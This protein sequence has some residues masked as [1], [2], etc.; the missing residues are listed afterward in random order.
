MLPTACPV[1]IRKE[2]ILE[3]C[4]IYSSLNSNIHF[5]D[6]GYMRWFCHIN[7]W[8]FP[9][10]KRPTTY[11]APVCSSVVSICSSVCLPACQPVSL[12][13]TFCLS[14]F[15]PV[16]FVF[17]DIDECNASVPVCDINAH[18]QNTR[19]SYMCSC[20][21]GFTGDG[22]ICT[23]AGNNLRGTV[24]YLLHDI[25]GGENYPLLIVDWS[26]S[27]HSSRLW[28]FA[29][30]VSNSDLLYIRWTGFAYQLLGELLYYFHF[31]I[32]VSVWRNS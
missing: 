2:H 11:A 29:L 1:R 5:G 8:S 20:K 14:G 17:I 15:I 22:K 30:I 25:S 12:F 26:V 3:F 23:H 27:V 10:I 32:N 21:A 31:R 16:L 19:G 18:C 7:W 24:G 9:E 4:N 13:L 6:L 28:R